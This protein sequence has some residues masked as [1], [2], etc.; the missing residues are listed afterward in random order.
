MSGNGAVVWM[1]DLY[2]SCCGGCGDWIA[3]GREMQGGTVMY[4][5]VVKHESQEGTTVCA[6]FK[7]HAGDGARLSMLDSFEEKKKKKRKKRSGI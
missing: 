1:L 6:P 3:D 4:E 2:V 5:K 7:T